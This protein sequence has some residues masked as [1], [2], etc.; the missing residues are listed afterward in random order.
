MEKKL[1]KKMKRRP[2]SLL[3]LYAELS[4]VQQSLFQ[5]SLVGALTVEDS[6]VYD[7]VCSELA[8]LRKILL[9]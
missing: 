1:L 2:K 5:K 7:K 9:K 3:L 4:L 6:I 8:D